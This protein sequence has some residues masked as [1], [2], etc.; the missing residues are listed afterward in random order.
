[1]REL[2]LK[3]QR[4]FQ[5]IGLFTMKFAHV[6]LVVTP[7]PHASHAVGDLLPGKPSALPARAVLGRN[8]TRTRALPLS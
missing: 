1:V 8:R 5:N 3:M 4:S 2:F 7:R 6:A